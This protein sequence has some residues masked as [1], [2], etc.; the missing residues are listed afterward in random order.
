[1]RHARSL[2]MLLMDADGLKAVNDRFGHQEGDR[3]LQH[4]AALLRREARA[5]DIIARVGGDEF[6]VIQPETAVAG[7]LIAA[8]RIRAAMRAEPYA[9]IAGDTPLTSLSIG[10]SG[11][12]DHAS[13]SADLFRLADSA[14]YESKRAGKDRTTIA[15]AGVPA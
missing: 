13:S 10:V 4:I 8:E 5:S 6:A 7:G 15:T 9:T 12:P 14:L 1:V 3:L 11:V 2:A